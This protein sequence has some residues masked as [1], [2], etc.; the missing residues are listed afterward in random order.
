[1]IRVFRAITGAKASDANHEA[2]RVYPIAVAVA[3]GIMTGLYKVI[4]VLR[5]DLQYRRRRWWPQ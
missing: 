1:M 2:D 3:N 4:E 5:A